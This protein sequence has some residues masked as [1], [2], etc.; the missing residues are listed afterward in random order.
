MTWIIR[1]RQFFGV[2]VQ[3][4]E[5]LLAE[6]LGVSVRADRADEFVD[7][8]DSA[9]LEV[10]RH[11]IAVESPEISLT[12]KGLLMPSSRPRT[13]PSRSRGPGRRPAG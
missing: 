5:Q 13:P 8:L 7:V 4:R 2:P 12:W 9:D 10:V 6:C 3:P 11:Q 1:P